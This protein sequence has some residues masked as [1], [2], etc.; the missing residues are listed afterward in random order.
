MGKTYFSSWDYSLKKTGKMFIF[1]VVDSTE[2]RTE[3]IECANEAFL[4]TIQEDFKNM[5]FVGPKGEEI[6]IFTIEVSEIERFKQYELSKI[7]LS[8]AIYVSL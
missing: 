5:T 7:S 6:R 4:R 8:P 1:Q 2:V 3:Q